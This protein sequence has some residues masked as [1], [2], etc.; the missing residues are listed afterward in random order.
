MSDADGAPVPDFL[1]RLIA[2]HA[3]AAAG[4]RPDVVRVRPRLPGPF[5]RI[6]A[7]RGTAPEPDDGSD[8]LWPATTPTHVR[9][10]PA[11]RPAPPAARLH[12]ERERTVVR[13]ERAPADPAPHP[14][15]R[16][17]PE[18]PLLRPVTPIAPG[19]RPAPDAGQRA[20][21]RGRSERSATQ[22]A[23]SVP[24]PPGA[25]AATSAAVSTPLRPSAADTAAARDAVRQ[26]A[27]RRPARAPEQVVQVQIGRLE[28]TSG[29]TPAGGSRQ[30]TPAA[31][32]PGAALS[33]AEYL[34]R[35]RK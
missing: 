13:T 25:D 1:D 26:A 23:A 15:P 27:A 8:P 11:P 28:V 18:A 20:A 35:G 29:P 21:G 33:L 30:R 10:V 19:P 14:A 6:E 34:A 22:S 31:E 12:T 4:P 7:V 16:P 2:R 5:E 24:N 9:P 32:R 17:L 3:P